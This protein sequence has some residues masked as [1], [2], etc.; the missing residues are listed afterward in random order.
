MKIRKAKEKESKSDYLTT[1]SLNT[2]RELLSEEVA[3]TNA[4]VSVNGVT[5]MF[6]GT[7]FKAS[8]PLIL[9]FPSFRS[10]GVV[11]NMCCLHFRV[12]SKD[13]LD[14]KL[15]L[16]IKLVDRKGVQKGELGRRDKTLAVVV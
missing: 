12:R 11:R 9:R 15:C 4:E 5:T 10:G 6:S 7:S 2:C 8:L 1:P 14:K 3:P 16:W 13:L